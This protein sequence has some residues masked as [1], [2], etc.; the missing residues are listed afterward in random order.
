MPATTL[1]PG[2]IAW[3]QTL[4]LT[5]KDGV[6]LRAGLWRGGDRGLVLLL[7]G[8]TEFLEKCAVPAAALVERGFSVA[9]VDW[10]G[11]GLSDRLLTNP[12]KGH[13]DRF[14]DYH[15][16]LTALMTD[17]AVAG[18]GGKRIMLAHSM[19]G[20][21]GLGAVSRGVLASDAMILSSPMLGIAL[22]MLGRLAASAMLPVAR[23]LG[24]LDRWPPF[25]PGKPYVFGPF[26][27]NVLTGDREIFEWMASALQAEPRL[28]LASPTL[29]WLDAALAETGFLTRQGALG[30]P[31]L[32]LLGTNEAV[33]DTQAIRS[34]AM[35]LEAELVEIEGAQH[36]VLIETAGLRA[37]AWAA[38]DGFLERADI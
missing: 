20:A 21:I 6:R 30:C 7:N 18:I 4:D 19:G 26:N 16:D 8:R 9:S 28:Q 11:Q 33:V 15:S 13:V 25:A 27:G 37:E 23:A 24:K 29:G 10:R 2:G 17:P 3:D 32:C 1:P 36:E 5:A 12:L 31:V 38:I 22:G 35:R 34:G 14:T